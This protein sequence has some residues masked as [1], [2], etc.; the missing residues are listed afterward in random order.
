MTDDSEVKLIAMPGWLG[1][2]F[3]KAPKPKKIVINNFHERID[4][5]DFNNSKFLGDVRL[6]VVLPEEQ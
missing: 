6:S 5:I 1:N 2:S 3:E 4:E